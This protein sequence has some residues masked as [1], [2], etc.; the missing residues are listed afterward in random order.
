MLQHWNCARVTSPDIW[1]HTLSQ[2]PSS[3][4]PVCHIEGEQRQRPF[5]S[6]S[7]D[8]FVQLGRALLICVLAV[9]NAPPI[10][11]VRHEVSPQRVAF[12]LL[13]LSLAIVTFSV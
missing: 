8:R 1:R 5:M 3:R 7:I 12:L 13:S 6:V 2:M 11:H 10:M 9:S 4:H